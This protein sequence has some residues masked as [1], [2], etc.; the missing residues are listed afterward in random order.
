MIRLVAD[1]RDTQQTQGV[2][3]SD[4]F[5]AASSSM[6]FRINNNIPLPTYGDGMGAHTGGAEGTFRLSGEGAAAVMVMGFAGVMVA[7][8]GVIV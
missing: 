4:G 5:P 1:D 8:A 2:C 3:Y 6:R 7:F